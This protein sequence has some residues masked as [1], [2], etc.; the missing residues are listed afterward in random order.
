M[1]CDSNI[2]KSRARAA[3]GAAPSNVHYGLCLVTIEI[4]SMAVSKA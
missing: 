4:V 3:G 1:G 2:L